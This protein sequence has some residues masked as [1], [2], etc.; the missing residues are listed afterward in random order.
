[1]GI[2][3]REQLRAKDARIRTVLAG[4]GSPLW[5]SAAASP[6][7]G[8]RSK[9]KM[10]I[11]GS[12][13]APTLGIL[14]ENQRGVDLR[15][16][17]ILSAGLQAA[18]SPIARF[19]TRAG[20]VPYDVAARRGEGKYAILTQAPSGELMAR[21]V[22]R[23]REPLGRIR[24]HLP[25]L[26]HELPQLRVVSVNLHAVHAAVLEGD[27][28]IPLTEQQ[29]LDYRLDELSLRLGPRSFVQTNPAIARELYRA[30]QQ[31]L[32]VAAPSTVWDLYCGIGGF[33]LSLAAHD[34]H[35]TGVESSEEAVASATS[36]A[37]TAGLANRVRFLCADAT[38]FARE[39][40]E[41]PDCVVVNPPRRGLG[42]TLSTWL[43]GSDVSTVLYSS[44]NP[45]SLARDLAEMPSLR[46]IRARLFDMFPQTEHAEVL[47]LLA[48]EPG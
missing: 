31:W 29:T 37:R 21:F 38:A 18:M 25:S 7:S 16:C 14:D 20:V 43:E 45:A 5:E 19:L 39:A 9:A 1:M 23:S 34:R 15:D 33:A 41:Q 48:R 32:D 26:Q 24:K 12:V 10:V 3:Y 44:C 46:P 6:E 4:I 30:A 35:V 36:A 17:G 11:G 8:F 42:T 40:A 27:E 22:L 47:V 28:E 13:D 2:P